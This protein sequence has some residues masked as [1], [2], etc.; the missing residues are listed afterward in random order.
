[1]N[2]LAL[3]T[4][5]LLLIS[6]SRTIIKNP[7]DALRPSPSQIELGDD[8]DAGPLIAGLENHIQALQKSGFS[9]LKFGPVEIPKDVYIQELQYLASSR[10]QKDFFFRLSEKFQILEVYGRDD[11]SEILLTSYYGPKIQGS[12]TKTKKFNQAL[13]LPPKD[14]VEIPLKKF[15]DEQYSLESRRSSVSGK[16]EKSETGY[17]FRV[18]PHFSRCQIDQENALGGQK[19]EIVYVDRIEAFFLQIQGSGAVELPDGKVIRLGYAAQNG[20]KYESIGKFLTDFIPIEKMSLQSI[21]EYLR[22]LGEDELFQVLCKNPSYVFFNKLKTRPITTMGSE[23]ID[24]RTLA[25]DSQ[26]FPLGSLGFLRFP[27]PEDDKSEDELIYH[28][29]IVFLQ[30][31]GGAIKGADRA[32]LFWGEGQE[33]KQFAGKMR[34]K[35]YLYLFI[36]KEYASRIDT[37][38]SN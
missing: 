37:D 32:D 33:A 1:M 5:L 6:C 11:W 14:L 7:D 12:K 8:G 19:L 26:M 17:P 13:Y 22:T 34:H 30:D 2:L 4:L 38:R 15:D 24:G 16:L 21:E 36:P 9:T 3:T 35:S 18:V 23:V 29:R 20:M 25:V 10:S 31:T 28:N 27:V